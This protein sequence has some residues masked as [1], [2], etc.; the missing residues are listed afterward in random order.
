[1]FALK[2]TGQVLHP[3]VASAHHSQQKLRGSIL[4]EQTEHSGKVEI[5]ET[6]HTNPNTVVDVATQNEEGHRMEVSL[7][8]NQNIGIFYSSFLVLFDSEISLHEI[9]DSFVFFG[10]V[11][12]LVK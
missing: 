4:V 2:V 8:V 5:F 7:F 12:V 3:W 9:H 1:M 10:V 6:I 11:P